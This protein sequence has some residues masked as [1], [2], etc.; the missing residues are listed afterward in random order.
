MINGRIVHITAG[1][2]RTADRKGDTAMSTVKFYSSVSNA[3]RAAIKSNGSLNGLQLVTTDKGYA[4]QPAPKKAPMKAAEKKAATKATDAKRQ[5]AYHIDADR[6]TKNGFTRPSADT[7]GG[8]L[9][10]SFDDSGKSLDL[11]GAKVRGEN[12]GVNATS[13]VIAFYR[14]RR[15]NGIKSRRA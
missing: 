13:T 3:R 11:A 4:Y 2:Y 7:V 8:R 10:A 9:W 1:Q 12:L 14:W 6:P 5:P 15:F